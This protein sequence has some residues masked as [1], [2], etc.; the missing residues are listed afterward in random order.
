MQAAT[1]SGATQDSRDWVRRSS[2][3][4]SLGRPGGCTPKSGRSPAEPLVLAGHGASLQIDGGSLLIRNGLTHYPQERETFRYFKGDLSLPSRIIL[5]D[6]TGTLSFD[7]LGW[8]S[9][10][11]VPLV[12]IDWRGNVQTVASN[13]G[14]ASNQRRLDWQTETRANPA[15]RMAFCIDLIARKIEG[16]ITVLE[17]AVRQSADWEKAMRRAY[18]DLTRLEC[19][20]PTDIVTLRGLEAGCAAAYFRAWRHIPVKWVATSRRPVPDFWRSVGRRASPYK[21]TGNRNARDPI[22]A[23]LNY[24]YAALESETRIQAVSEGYDPS[25]GIMHDRKDSQ[26]GFIFDLMEPERPKV[27]RAVLEFV[28]ANPLHAADLTITSDGVCRLN[29]EMA[30]SLVA[31]I[32][33]RRSP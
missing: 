33:A 29:P 15:K 32:G 7:A 27:D 28:K 12:R 18:G 31:A 22:N 19:D 11:N 4:H 24:G 2:H 30:K 21:V 10:Q 17:K 13:S 1:E 5:L 26:S 9:E 20:P 23:M 6:C 25:R 8:L 3:W 14:Y 16:C